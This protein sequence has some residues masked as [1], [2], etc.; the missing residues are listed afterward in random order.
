MDYL[1]ATYLLVRQE[2]GKHSYQAIKPFC[3][4]YMIFSHKALYRFNQLKPSSHVTAKLP[5]EAFR[6]DKGLGQRLLTE[7]AD[8][9]GGGGG[10]W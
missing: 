1:T 10:V 7:T 9:K 8:T 5:L 2:P 6:V 4:G 3:L